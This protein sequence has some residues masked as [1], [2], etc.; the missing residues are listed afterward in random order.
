MQTMETN[1]YVML[2]LFNAFA[3]PYEFQALLFI[4][5]M[6][7]TITCMSDESIHFKVSGLIH[8]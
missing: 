1:D 5:R 8:L 4:N 6:T 2:G 7:I 3:M